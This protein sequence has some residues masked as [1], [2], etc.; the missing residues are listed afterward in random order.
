MHVMWISD[1]PDT[2]S[3][4]GNVTRFVC[5]GLARRGH[6]VSILGWQTNEHREWNGCEVFPLCLDPL[7]GLPSMKS[8][9]AL[10]RLLVRVRPHLVIALGDVWWLPYFSAPQVRRQMEMTDAPW[11]LYFP[12]DG[13]MNG[14]RLPPSWLEILREVDIPVAMSRYGQRI[15]KNG[16]ISCEYVPHGVDLDV[17]C[18]PA[19][20]EAA[21]ARIGAQGK[22]VVLSDCRNQP[23]KMLPR[24]L[25]VFAR[26]SQGRP[27]T[28]LHLHTDPEDDFSK[29]SNIYSYSVLQ[30]VKHLG[31]EGRVRFSPKFQMQTGRG[32]PLT[33]LAAYY[34]AADVFLLASSGE[35]FGLP[36]LQA[37]AAGAVPMASAYS[38]SQELVEGHGESIAIADWTENEFGVR[39]AL[40]DIEDAADKLAIY[41]RDRKLLRERS[42]RCRSF[43]APYAWE[44][45]I[46]QW[47]ALLG[48]VGRRRRR[49]TREH[50]QTPAA[51]VKE[52]VSSVTRVPA[53]VSVDIKMVAHEYGRLE[54]SILADARG[55]SSDVKIPTVPKASVTATV[56]V[57]RRF[58]YIGMGAED[59]G[60]FKRLRGIFPVL[61]AWIAGCVSDEEY[62]DA[63]IKAVPLES[64]EEARL[65]LAQSVLFLNVSGRIPDAVLAD[66]AFLGV[67][68]VGTDTSAAQRILWPQL[69]A[70]DEDE[71]V[72]LG[73]RL[74]T[75]AAFATHAVESAREACRANY[76]PDEQN[77]A[78]WLRRISAAQQEPAMAAVRG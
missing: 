51:Q 78:T 17:F 22:F 24:L 59:V 10:Y 31:L 14:E 35:G 21:K 20:R 74:L 11:L 12:I 30:D 57:I 63:E 25:E 70:H 75:D 47:D 38:A 19:D 23:R 3:G 55:R 64:C 71:A 56:K 15:V 36:T 8:S 18:P 67:P 60:I 37:A 26:F 1:S 40:I 58:G 50:P 7:G 9:D 6:R 62:G 68:C 49:I 33:E 39:R 48:S 77:V 43:A 66:A 29:F 32:L 4:F 34:Q 65:D 13:D 28:L 46:D 76:C 54:A 2:P 61:S 53:G 69:V 42:L 45:V 5:E 16:G 72:I 52:L 41:Y 27:D 73:R 44:N